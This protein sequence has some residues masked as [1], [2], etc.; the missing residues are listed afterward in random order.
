MLTY[1]AAYQ[2]VEGGVHAH[3]MD[4]PGAITCGPDLNETRRLLASAMRDLAEIALER[5]EPLPR[6][7]P[8]A[9]DPEADIEEPIHLHLTASTEAQTMPAGIVVA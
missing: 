8:S 5:G 1:K 4:F 2:F 7:D 6:P 9:K 3:V